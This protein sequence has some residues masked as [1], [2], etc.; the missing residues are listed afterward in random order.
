MERSDLLTKNQRK[1]SE[2]NVSLVFDYNPK[3]FDPAQKVRE[4]S[5]NLQYVNKVKIGKRKEPN[6]IVARRQPLNLLRILTLSK[7]RDQ[8][9]QHFNDFNFSKCRDKR[10]ETCE[11]VIKEQKYTTKNGYTLRRNFKFT[12]KSRDFIMS[13]FVVAVVGNMLVKRVQS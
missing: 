8:N 1:T 4:L 2:N 3:I 6:I 12:C 13:L 5:T 11:I 9:I 10:C 7:V